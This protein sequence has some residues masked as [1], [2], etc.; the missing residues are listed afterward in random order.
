MK[1]DFYL[2]RY[3]LIIKKLESAPATYSQMEDYLLNSFEFQDAGIKSY[4]I[5]TLQR[6]IREISDLLTFL[7][8][9]KRKVTIG[10]TSKVAQ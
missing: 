2:T 8:T 5:R 9:T 6:D 1:K 7:F 3:A 4:S 10:I